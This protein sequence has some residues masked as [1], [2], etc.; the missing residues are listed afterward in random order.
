MEKESQEMA[1]NGWGPMVQAVACR[2]HHFWTQLRSDRV[3]RWADDQSFAIL[4]KLHLSCISTLFF[5]LSAATVPFSG[6]LLFTL[7]AH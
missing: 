7:F 2:F 1:A 4:P 6:D 5:L 3:I